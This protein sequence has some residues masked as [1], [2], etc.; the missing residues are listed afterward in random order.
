MFQV[1][2][3]LGLLLIFGVAAAAGLK[4][5]YQDQGFGGSRS[6]GDGQAAERSTAADSTAPSREMV[7]T[8][9][10]HGHYWL[11]AEI[12]GV[13]VRFLVDTGASYVALSP[14]DSR[15]LGFDNEDLEFSGVVQTANGKTRVAPVVLDD[16]RVG[17]LEVEDVT[18]V[19]S[20][21]DMGASLLGMSFL[22]K[23]DG[24]QVVDGQL[25]LYW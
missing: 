15:R 3:N 14:R 20:K 12:D 9:G 25:I 22:N 18:A 1:I 23:L 19:V 11:T 16:I 10:A 21:A 8:R 7:L 24:F 6:A 2:R 17:Q 13:E 4:F 5:V